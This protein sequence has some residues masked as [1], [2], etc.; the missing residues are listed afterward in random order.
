MA[1][2]Y[3]G[4]VYGAFEEMNDVGIAFVVRLRDEATVEVQEDLALTEEADQQQKV[5]GTAWVRLAAGHVAGRASSSRLGPEGRWR[6]FGAGD[7]FGAGGTERSR[8]GV[9]L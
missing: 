6:N 1:D 5:I 4:E 2:R 7:Q 8:P 9:A 3:Y